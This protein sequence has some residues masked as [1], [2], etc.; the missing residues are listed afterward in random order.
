MR[1]RA[2]SVTA[3][4]NER[5]A[6]AVTA[7]LPGTFDAIDS[8]PGLLFGCEGDIEAAEPGHDLALSC[9]N[10]RGEGHRHGSFQITSRTLSH[11]GKEGFICAK[12]QGNCGVNR[13]AS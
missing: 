8:E 1:C 12:L 2:H 9:E 6:G 11:P 4:E 13:F 5:A 7:D 3:A 10:L